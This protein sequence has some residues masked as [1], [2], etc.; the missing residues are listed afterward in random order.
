MEHVVTANHTVQRGSAGPLLLAALL[1]AVISFQLNA[2]MLNPAIADMQ[3]RL[4]ATAGEVGLQ[5]TVFFM[6][7]ALFG[8]FLPRLSDILGR[9][10]IML[11]VLAVMNTGTVVALLAPN[12]EVL[13]VARGIQG[14]SGVLVPMSLLVMRDAISPMKFGTYMGIIAS[15]NGGVAGVDAIIGGALAD[16][17]G[18]RGIFAVTLVIGLVAIALVG[19]WGLDS[20]PSPGARMDWGG[21]ALLCAA[22]G[23][24]TVGV[25]GAGE[26]GWTSAWALAL[27]V[28]AVVLF[29]VWYAVERRHPEPLLPVRQL[30]DRA[31][32]ALLLT[33]VLTLSG[34]F[35]AINFVVP[36]LAENHDAGFG[37]SASLTSLL[38]L[39]PYAVVGWLTGPFA[40]RFAPRVG[41]RLVLR[42]GLVGSILAL[43][44]M[45]LGLSM[46]WVL[47]GCVVLL[48]VC[49]AGVGNIMLNGLGV[50]LSP[51]ENEG[52]LPGLNSAAFNVGASLGVGVL[53]PLVSAGSPAGSTS[54]AGY[55]TALIVAVVISVLA[56]AVSYLLPSRGRSGER[57]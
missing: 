7:A 48:G 41:W 37:M 38:F 13:Y 42:I 36:S 45:F 5:A 46:P 19:L 56:L 43:L 16:T 14:V 1:A 57:V 31:T 29:V 6:S 9:K 52:M 10:P 49:Y 35:A 39:T 8:V 34:A 24:L 50:V 20:R 23:A 18:F 54:L 47:V 12:I 28:T 17:A 21:V 32:W 44:P 51:P 55:R 11:G 3:R 2:T 30:K 4:G 40:G 22:I 27:L 33:T 15:V 26:A 53:A 25:S